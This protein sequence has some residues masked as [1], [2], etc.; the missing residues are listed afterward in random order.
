MD[1][2]YPFH[3]IVPT[4]EGPVLT[5]L[6][7]TTR[8]L[9]GREIHRLAEVGSPGGVR[10]ALTRL[11]RQ[12]VVSA[13]ERAG[14]V[15]YQANRDHLAWPAVKILA[16]LRRTMLDR[17][18]HELRSWL[19]TPLHA[20]MFGSAARGDGDADSDVDILLVRPD[21]L[22]EDEPTWS[23]Q[24]DRLRN[25]VTTW[26]GNRCQPFQLDLSQLA[27]HVR[28]GDP[29][30]DEWRRDAILLAGDDL[31]VVLQRIRAGGVR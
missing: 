23:E 30:I 8:P 25:D 2:S 1:L 27:A 13:E 9:T 11:T 14:A 18:R 19:I 16:G 31:R 21:E 12:G 4:L 7:R 29:L 5:V 17:I 26:T 6:A 3:V 28:A 20:S 22:E 15:F 24:V 10:L